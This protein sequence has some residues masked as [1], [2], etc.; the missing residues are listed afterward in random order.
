ML[1]FIFDFKT[2]TQYGFYAPLFIT[3]SVAVFQL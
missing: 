1:G 2:L 3:R